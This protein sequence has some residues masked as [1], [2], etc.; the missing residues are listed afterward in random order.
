MDLSALKTGMKGIIKEISGRDDLALQL[1]EMGFVPGCEVAVVSRG[2]FNGPL[3]VAVRGARIA[4]RHGEA[5]RI[6]I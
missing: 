2:P 3:A 5:K 6:K 1:L 4:L